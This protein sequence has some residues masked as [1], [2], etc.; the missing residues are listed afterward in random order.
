MI[1][2]R[3]KYPGPYRAFLHEWCRYPEVREGDYGVKH[4]FTDRR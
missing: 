3:Y 4:L 1:S 2:S